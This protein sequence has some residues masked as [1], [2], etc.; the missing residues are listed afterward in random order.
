MKQ[1]ENRIG[2]DDNDGSRGFERRNSF[3][4]C[5][6]LHYNNSANQAMADVEGGWSPSPLEDELIHPLQEIEVETNQL[7]EE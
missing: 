5:E 6:D 2:G 1:N 3:N 7:M 4:F